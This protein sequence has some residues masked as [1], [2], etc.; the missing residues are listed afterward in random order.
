VIRRRGLFRPREVRRII[1]ANLSGREDYNLQV[2]QLMTLELW[3]RIFI[4]A[5]PPH[6]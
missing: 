1:A 4:D 5:K 2:F 6:Y 3:Q